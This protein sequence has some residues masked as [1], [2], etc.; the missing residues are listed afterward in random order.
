MVQI[1]LFF[2]ACFFFYFVPTRDAHVV[3]MKGVRQAIGHH[4]VLQGGVAHLHTCSHVQGV[5]S[6]CA[7]QPSYL[8]ALSLRKINNKVPMWLPCSCSPCPLPRPP[9]TLQTWWT[10][11]PDKRPS[12]QSHTPSGSSTPALGR[13]CLPQR[14]PGESGSDHDLREQQRE[15]RKI[16]LGI[17]Q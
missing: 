8:S 6:L 16:S 14:W 3:V 15:K 13:G 12:A 5:R 1:R 9:W 17:G 7:E 11:L 4:G 2:Q 10:E